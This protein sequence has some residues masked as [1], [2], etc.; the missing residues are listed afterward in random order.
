MQLNR[1]DTL[2]NGSIGVRVNP[3]GM[4]FLEQ[5]I[6][7]SFV[8]SEGQVVSV[9]GELAANF[10]FAQ[11]GGEKQFPVLK[12]TNAKDEENAFNKH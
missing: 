11:Q 2:Q 4:Y 5:I 8:N 6:P 12:L 9:E 1:G 3:K 7:I 10:E